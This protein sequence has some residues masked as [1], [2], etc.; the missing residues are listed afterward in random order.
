MRTTRTMYLCI[1]PCGRAKTSSEG[2]VVN[3]SEHGGQLKTSADTWSWFDLFGTSHSKVVLQTRGHLV[4]WVYSGI[5]VRCSI[6]QWT[7][8]A[9]Y[10]VGRLP[11][12]DL[13]FFM[14]ANA[15]TKSGH[16]RGLDTAWSR[17]T[18]APVSNMTAQFICM[19][20]SGT[21]VIDAAY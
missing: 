8:E 4:S 7:Q 1:R 2:L 20:P 9:V 14:G 13:G 21:C 15:P 16:T 5:W 12:I 11:D 18:A 6:K 19:H 17:R 3:A 10:F